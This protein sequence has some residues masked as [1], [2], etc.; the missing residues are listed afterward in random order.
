MATAQVVALKP[1]AKS[2]KQVRRT[3]R[4]I[5][6][7]AV[8]AGC[9]GGVAALIT[10]LSLSHLASGVK[11]ITCCEPWEAWAMSI[12]IDCGF[13]AT[14]F[15]TLVV[16]EKLR[17]KIATLANATIVGTLAGSAGMNVYA[18]AAQ[19]AN[20]YAL[21]AAVALGLAIPALIFAF[22][23]LGAAL[24]FDCHNRTA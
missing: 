20:P 9:I 7:Q 2:T 16:G 22:M 23:R 1:T 13:V 6:R 18:F 5:R 21:A 12:A 24:W 19:A 10:A 11:L 8:V 14:K 15:C 3:T 17:K 4:A